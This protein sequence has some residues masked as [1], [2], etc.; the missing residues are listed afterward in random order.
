MSDDGEAVP[1]PGG[2]GADR[3]GIDPTPAGP[4]RAGDVL[5]A[6]RERQGLSLA[7]VAQRTRVPLRQLEAVETGDYASLPSHT[8][9]TGFAK[10]YAR[11]V[12]EDEV[13]IARIVRQEID[14]SGPRVPEYRP[15]EV[16]D[17]ARVPSRGLAAVALGL[18]V[19]VA[20]LVGLWYATDLFRGQGAGSPTV[21]AVPPVAG[22][23]PIVP[24][25]RPS[26]TTGPVVLSAGANEVWMRVYEGREGGRTLYLGTLAPGARFELP[27]DAVQPLINVGR[28]DQLTITVGGRAV[29]PLGDG[30]RA[31]KDVA[32]DA[33]ALAARAN[34]QPAAAPPVAS[35]LPAEPATR[36]TA[37]A[38][39]RPR[40]PRAAQPRRELSETQRANLGSATPAA[41]PATGAAPTP[42]GTAPSPQ[43]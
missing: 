30:R 20:V 33:A 34:G 37:A 22:P 2:A 41:A 43:P 42:A 19:A 6:A 17:P 24:A 36:T 28:P 32:I 10:A 11:A 1:A 38:S 7:D 39:P 13:A 8:Y 27:A 40:T 18:A 26:P 21:V 31:I 23:A 25:T 16:A 15:Q 35:P 29:P 4:A 9:A 3:L 12:G 14:R 5:R